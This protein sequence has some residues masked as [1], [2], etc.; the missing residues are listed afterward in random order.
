MIS[1]LSLY[2]VSRDGL[3]LFVKQLEEN[4]GT[5]II[6]RLLGFVGVS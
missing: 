4:G 2:T 1:D 5:E 6:Q 3:E